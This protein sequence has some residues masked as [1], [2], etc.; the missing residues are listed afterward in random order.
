VSEETKTYFAG[1]MSQDK[2]GNQSFG[3]RVFTIKAPA[4]GH[5]VHDMAVSLIPD[6][7]KRKE[8]TLTTL[9]RID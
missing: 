8:F 7:A 4:T 2:K 9:N 6:D 1:Y 5:E 3:Y